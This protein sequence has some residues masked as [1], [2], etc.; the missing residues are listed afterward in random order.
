MKIFP[1]E[2]VRI[3]DQYTIEHEPIPSIDLMERAALKLKDWYVRRYHIDK[4]VVV[5]AGPGNNGGDALALARM[6]ADRQYRVDCYLVSASGR[7]SDDC[8]ANL[9]RLELQGLV[10]IKKISSSDDFPVVEVGDV[11]IDGLFGSGL[12]R[13]VD[14]VYRELIAYINHCNTTVLSIDIPSGLFGEDNSSN[15]PEAIMEADF[16]LTF[17]FPFLSFFFAENER[18]TGIWEVLDI[19]LHPEIIEQTGTGYTVTERQQIASMLPVRGRFA[20]KG[21]FG[22]ALVIAGSSGMMGAALLTGGAVLRSGA[23]LVTLHVPKAGFRV[24]Q[25]AFPE[26]I[27]NLDQMDDCFSEP[28]VT[29]KYSAVAIGPGLGLDDKSVN[30]LQKLLEKTEAPLVI[31]ADALN[32]IAANPLLAGLIPERSI[33]TPHPLEFDRI[34]GESP[35]AW[36][37]HLRQIEYSVSH[38]VIVVLKGAFTGISFPD[39]TYMFNSTGN[40]G[41]ATGGSGDVLTGIIVSLLAQGLSPEYSA[42]AGVF[43][44]GMA[45]D[46]AA[47]KFGQESMIAGDIIKC[48]GDAFNK[49]K[50]APFLHEGRMGNMIQ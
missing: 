23:G 49:V 19:G 13:V 31:D 6:L 27:V 29:G 12:T 50:A 28:P 33:L 42:T 26:A 5:L 1:A 41:M 11:F 34:A 17:Q 40:P 38:K 18:Y 22:H 25:T 14:G 8:S 35:D 9:R 2:S 15:D 47:E 45:G 4:K 37:R 30:G 20:H 7:L 16:T 39:G 32:M 46:L 43:L 36:S 24:V 44:H 10:N 21:T 3:I 48:L